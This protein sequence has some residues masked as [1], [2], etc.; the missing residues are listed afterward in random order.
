MEDIKDF[1]RQLLVPWQDKHYDWYNQDI[2]H[3]KESI[4]TIFSTWTEML[5]CSAD[6]LKDR[7]EMTLSKAQEEECS[8][9]EMD[10]ALKLLK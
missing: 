7:A 6:D 2:Q 5:A 4:D 9:K 10:A 8:A 1:E 3:F